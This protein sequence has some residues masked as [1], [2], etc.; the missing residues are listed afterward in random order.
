MQ[1]GGTVFCSSSRASLH[2]TV[3]STITTAF[4]LLVYLLSQLPLTILLFIQSTLTEETVLSWS[5]K[6]AMFSKFWKLPLRHQISTLP[7]SDPRTSLL[8]SIHLISVVPDSVEHPALQ[9]CTSGAFA[10]SL[11]NHNDP[12]HVR[13]VNAEDATASVPSTI[14]LRPLREKQNQSLRFKIS[15]Q[16]IR[17]TNLPQ[18]QWHQRVHEVPLEEPPYFLHVRLWGSN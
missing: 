9:Y 1:V 8:E 10:R 6:D 14:N 11:N 4:P 7:E 18:Y 2:N 3:S 5:V 12:F 15:K 13:P 17:N 16:D